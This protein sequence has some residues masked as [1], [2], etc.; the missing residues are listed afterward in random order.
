M[1]PHDSKISRKQLRR[2]GS[3]RPISQPADIMRLD[4]SAGT[5]YY[6]RTGRPVTDRDP[7]LWEQ[8]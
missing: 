7:A 2:P 1:Q 5:F 6:V 4:P 8:A 3:E